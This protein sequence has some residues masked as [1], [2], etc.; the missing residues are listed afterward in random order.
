M[1]DG[2]EAMLLDQPQRPLRASRLPIPRPGPGELLL[3]VHACG[4]CR[5]DLH[6]ADGELPEPKLPLILGHEIVGTV[7]DRGSGAERFRVGDRVGVPWLGWTCGQ[8]RFCRSGQE[9]LC[10][11]ARFTGYQVDGGYAQFTV[12]DERFCFSLPSRYPDAEAAP[13]LCAGLIG[14]RSLRVAGDAGRLGIYGFGA[15]AHLI[16]Q[17]ALHQGRAVYVF[18]RSGDAEG[19]EFA[20]ELGV[21]WAGASTERAPEDL[22]AA[23]IFAPVGDLVPVALRAVRPGGTV[24]CAGIHMT[25]IPSFPYAILWGERV[26]RSVANLTRQDGDEFFKVA[27]E[28]P[29]RVAVELL[30]LS[31]A[32]QGLDQLRAGRVRGAVVLIPPT[33]R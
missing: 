19:Q 12:A 1:I 5:T 11:R 24:V 4:I 32:P 30:P 2:M 27:S 25:P 21:T 6:L 29:L 16:A 8:C 15:A 26:L 9:N 28:V 10:E 23:I 7:S 20:R 22:D 18:T 31:E 17:I 14:Y 3:R 33:A 13:L